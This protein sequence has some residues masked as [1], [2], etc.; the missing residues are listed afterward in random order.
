MQPRGPFVSASSFSHARSFRVA[1]FEQLESRRL[2]SAGTPDPSFGF[3]G[4][5]SLPVE[6]EVTSIAAA[7][8]GRYYAV[9]SGAN[10]VFRLNANGSID[11]SFANQ[12]VVKLDRYPEDMLV[13]SDGKLLLTG[14]K[15]KPDFS[16]E[17]F[18]SRL[19]AAGSLDKKFGG[20]DGEFI[21]DV[22]NTGSGARTFE[23]RAGKLTVGTLL[24]PDAS[25]VLFRLHDDGTID[26]KFNGSGHATVRRGTHA[27]II[28]DLVVLGDGSTVSLLAGN[29]E[30]YTA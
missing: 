27:S 1:A 20:G 29:G 30:V 19:T 14:A 28:E 16:G 5:E 9:S 6:G 4:V 7:P 10:L 8:D 22:T 17:V 24:G 11:T 12:G 26:R 21:Y 3:E 18:V 23:L 25:P 15:L 2:L 13:Q